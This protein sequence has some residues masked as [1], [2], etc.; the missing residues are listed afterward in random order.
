[1]TPSVVEAA[2]RAS[3]SGTGCSELRFRVRTLPGPVEP[4][5]VYSAR[6]AVEHLRPRLERWFRRHRAARRIRLLSPVPMGRWVEDMTYLMER[7][8]RARFE[9]HVS[10]E[11]ADETSELTSPRLDVR[12]AEGTGRAW[13]ARLLRVA[14]SRPCPTIVLVGEDRPLVARAARLMCVF[15]DPLVASRAD[16]LVRALRA[17]R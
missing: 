7:F 2:R 11:C 1:M 5:A 8:P 10:R 15:C 3:P 16:H 6:A 9:V 14:R 13:L 17:L 12:V 4:L